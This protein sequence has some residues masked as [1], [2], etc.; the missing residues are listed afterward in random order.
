MKIIDGRNKIAG[1]AHA[2]NSRFS[3]S[4]ERFLATQ[5]F[6]I[7]LNICGKNRQLH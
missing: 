7:L 2:R 4:Y 5:K 3:A 1:L 6:V